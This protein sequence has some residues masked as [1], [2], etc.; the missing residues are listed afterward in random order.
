MLFVSQE[1]SSS[2]WPKKSKGKAVKKIIMNDNTFWPSVVYC[3][4]SIKPL[5]QVLRLVDGK[6]IPAM[7]FIYGVMDT[8]KEEI[9][10]NFD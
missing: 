5:V 7:R 8:T 1:W 9:A 10:K 2:A 3:I 4:K 6:K